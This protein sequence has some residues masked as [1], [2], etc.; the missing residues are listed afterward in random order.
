MRQW[1]RAGAGEW[2]IAATPPSAS[3]DFP[4][5]RP[6]GSGAS[7]ERIVIR[8]VREAGLLVRRLLTTGSHAQAG[9]WLEA[10]GP[11]GGSGSTSAEHPYERLAWLIVNRRLH[12]WRRGMTGGGGATGGGAPS[13][14]AT[15]AFARPE[16][17]P[18]RSPVGTAL[19]PRA[20]ARSAAI[21]SSTPPPP[22]FWYEFVLVDESGE[23]LPGVDVEFTTPA[24]PQRL[25][26]GP[27]GSVRVG[28]VPAG[29]ATTRVDRDS[30]AAALGDRAGR[31]RRKVPVPAETARFKVV[32]PQRATQVFRFAHHQRYGVMV[33][34]RTDV[35]MT[36]SDGRWRDLVVTD[37]SRNACRFTPGELDWLHL[38]SRGNGEAGRIVGNV[39]ASTDAPAGSQ[40]A[41]GHA[42]AR[43]AATVAVYEVRRGDSFWRVAEKVWG[44][45]RRWTEIRDANAGLMRNRPPNLIHPGDRLSIPLQPAAG[46][47]PAPEPWPEADDQPDPPPFVDLAID[48]LHEALFE[49]D[50]A[51]TFETLARALVRPPDPGDADPDRSA[52]T[53]AAEAAAVLAAVVAFE[54]GTF[55][56]E[57]FQPLIIPEFDEVERRGPPR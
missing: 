16:P 45:G 40:A 28:G 32:T 46:L 52:P 7:A 22:L 55:P 48:P 24:G 25:S 12:V 2:W 42:A 44:D 3:V 47:I 11:G 31:P 29:E 14:P 8:E 6:S 1:I 34:S 57:L 38:C 18:A 56:H 19:A 15:G 43:A 23:G 17:R 9:R 33:I 41:G 13:Q 36:G 37:P 53:A 27:D 21:V 20:R 5:R 10:A 30:L 39:A 4:G 51:A 50:G 26:T 35:V 54:Q 49:R